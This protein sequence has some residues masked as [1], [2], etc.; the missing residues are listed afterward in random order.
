[1]LLAA[2]ILPMAYICGGEFSKFRSKITGSLVTIVVL[3]AAFMCSALLLIANTMLP[4]NF[5]LLVYVSHYFLRL[6]RVSVTDF[7]SR[8]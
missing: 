6:R 4:T 3:K 7:Q 5:L 8:Y 2:F 1:M